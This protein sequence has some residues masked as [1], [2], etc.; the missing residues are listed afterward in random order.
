MG[1]VSGAGEKSDRIIPQVRIV[2]RA[3]LIGCVFEKNAANLLASIAEEI[4]ELL[5]SPNR[6]GFLNV[7]FLGTLSRTDPVLLFAELVGKLVPLDE[8]ESA[9]P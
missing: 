8:V 1:E 2:I 3:N 5:Q 6:S 4:S 7:V 9:S